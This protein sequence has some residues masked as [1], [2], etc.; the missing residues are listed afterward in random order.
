[1]LCPPTQLLFSL[2]KMRNLE[3][4]L[5]QGAQDVGTGW[6]TLTLTLASGPFCY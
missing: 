1:M 6:G 4:V 5:C 3:K 2:Y